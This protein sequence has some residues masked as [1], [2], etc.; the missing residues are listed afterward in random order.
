MHFLPFEKITQEQHNQMLPINLLDLPTYL[1]TYQ[2]TLPT[3]L[4]TYVPTYFEPL[5]VTSFPFSFFILLI[6]TGI[7]PKSPRNK[8][9]K[10]LF[11]FLF[12]SSNSVI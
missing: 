2:L 3:Y 5:I 11:F 8:G 12:L 7:P 6:F 9:K 1:P 10:T 4:P